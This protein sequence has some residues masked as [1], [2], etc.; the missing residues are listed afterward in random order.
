MNTFQ[1][2]CRSVSPFVALCVFLACV[3]GVRAQGISGGVAP[4]NMANVHIACVSVDGAPVEGVKVTT[5]GKPQELKVSAN[6]KPAH[7]QYIGPDEIA[8]YR[9]KPG[10]D[11]KPVQTP[12]AK[13]R[14]PALSGTFLVLFKRNP[15]QAE[16]YANFVIPDAE[17]AELNT[18]TVINLS[19]RQVAANFGTQQALLAPGDFKHLDM[20]TKPGYVEIACYQLVRREWVR[21]FSSR[22]YLR[23]RSSRTIF[24]YPNPHAPEVILYKGIDNVIPL[25][26]TKAGSTGRRTS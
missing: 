4:P 18:W 11:G 16:T 15:G 2:G 7:T 8:F 21:F 19:Q 13:T 1:F 26:A 6:Y 22:A 24:L 20:G 5:K 10:S 25:P 17:K 9:E 23:E 3:S 12:L 14:L